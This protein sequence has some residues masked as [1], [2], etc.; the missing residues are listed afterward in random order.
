MEL[1]DSSSEEELQGEDG[2]SSSDGSPVRS[3]SPARAQA[4]KRRRLGVDAK[5]GGCP[6]GVP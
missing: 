6:L 3:G 5:S 4:A 1:P 2:A